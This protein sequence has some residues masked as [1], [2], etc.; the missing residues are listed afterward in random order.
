VR[1]DLHTHS[2][3]SDGQDSP[4]ELMANARAARLDVVALTDHDTTYGWAEAAA[5]LPAGLQLV[6][7]AELSCTAGGI[8]LHLLAYLFDPTY[9][10]L[11]R[12]VGRAFGDRVG[13]ARKM[14]DLLIAAGYPLTW[15]AVL[16]E[17]GERAA[18]GRPHIADALVT[19]GVVPDRDA[20]F[21]E[22]LHNRSPFYLRHYALDP[23]EAVRL[24]RAA[25]GV[26][27]FAHPAASARGRTVADD[28]IVAMAAAGLAGLEVG[29][30]DHTEAARA[31]LRGL[32]G[33]LDLLVTGSSDYHGAGKDNRLG[34]NTTDPDVLE[35]L[36]AQARGVEV[37]AA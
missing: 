18:V 30:R 32:A 23:I 22:L 34:E 4:A 33:E 31:H 10:A 17:V 35:A 3:A 20:A 24:V 14:T 29:H 6:R 5:A 36:L 11:T 8:S 9:E 1:I 12:E 7:G 21:A 27:V 28:V 16:A 15:E 25:G 26:P 13:R 37:I 2:T 19:A